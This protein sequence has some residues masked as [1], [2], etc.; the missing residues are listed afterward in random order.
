M[1]HWTPA[2]NNSGH[3]WFP[4]S[5]VK[6]MNWAALPQASK[7][8][9]PVLA[10]H[11]N[12]KGECFPA[13]ER[14]A[15]LAG[16]T[17]KTARQGLRDL[18]G[19]PAY[20]GFEYYH[21]KLGKRSKRHHLILPRSGMVPLDMMDKG[22]TFPFHRVIIE[23][24]NWSLLL[25]TAQ[26]LYPVMRCFGYFDVDIYYEH[27]DESLS[28]SDDDTTLFSERKCDFCKTDYGLLARYAGIDRHYITRAIN[29]LIDKSLLAPINDYNGNRIFKV[30]LHPHR[31]YKVSFLN[32]QLMKRRKAV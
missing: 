19:F 31:Y 2:N 5:L 30:Y 17:E 11:A 10:I 27:V 16:V 6:D 15:A 9:F 12:N 7:T 29:D 22:Q 8:V 21:T 14:I 4:K 24:G 18:D 28:F 13:E 3:F 26:A 20:G 1:F 25:P 23:Y 32:E